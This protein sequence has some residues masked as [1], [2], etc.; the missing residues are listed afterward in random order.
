M[1][2]HNPKQRSFNMS[3]IKSKNTKPEETIRKTLWANG[4]RYRKNVKNLPGKPDIVFTGK[5]KMIFVN[6]CFWH[7]H[8]CKYFKWPKSREEFWKK[9][10]CDTA[11]RDQRN[12]EA[13]RTMGW[14]LLVIWECKIKEL[15]SEEIFK[16]LCAFL[17]DPDVGHISVL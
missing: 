14:K 9:K 7:M 13:L 8:D 5:K 17:E 2:V 12:Y 11:K 3:Q 4:Y 10:I 15:S 6:G 16:K 1:D